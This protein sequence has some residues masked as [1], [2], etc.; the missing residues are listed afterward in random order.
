MAEQKPYTLGDYFAVVRRRCVYPAVFLPAGILIALY[1]AFTLK[2]TYQSSATLMLELS[3]IPKDL[4]RTTVEAAANQEVELV[5]RRQVDGYVPVEAL[6]TGNDKAAEKWLKAFG[7][8]VVD[9]AKQ[10]GLSQDNLTPRA[11][12]AL[13]LAALVP[14]ALIWAESEIRGGAAAFVGAVVLLGVARARH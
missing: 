2:P 13:T 12:M 9:E 7:A 1:I 5:R 6:T 8:D 10:R 3:S 14:A 11:F 4:I